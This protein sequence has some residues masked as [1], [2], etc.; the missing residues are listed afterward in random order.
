MTRCTWVALCCGLVRHYCMYLGCFVSAK[1]VNHL[2]ATSY[3]DGG[4]V[5]HRTIEGGDNITV[6]KALLDIDQSAINIQ[7]NNGLS[8]LHLAC[9]LGRRKI[10]EQLLVRIRYTTDT[11][12]GGRIF[13]VF[14][15][16]RSA[17]LWAPDEVKK[18]G[19]H[20]V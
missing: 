4:T 9:R 16:S 13:F 20:K 2:C 7:D 10:I 14:P 6:L 15:I 3:S 12:K 18:I 11:C 8:P 17:H 1:H 19:C 5:Y